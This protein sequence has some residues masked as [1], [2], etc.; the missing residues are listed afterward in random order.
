MIKLLNFSFVL[1]FCLVAV[2]ALPRL[3]AFGGA[4]LA[5][6]FILVY[7]LVTQYLFVSYR[8][9]VDLLIPTGSVFVLYSAMTAYR[10]L[11]EERHA[12]EIKSMFSHY[13]TEKVVNE[14]L[15]HPELARLGG[16][17]REVT[18]LFSDVRSFT[19]YSEHHT[20]EE[21]VSALNELLSAMTDVIMHWDGTLDK[22]V[23]DEIMAFWGAPGNQ[24]NHAEL[25]TQCSLHML[26]RLGELQHKW[27]MEGKE[28]LDIGIGLNTGEVIVGNIGSETK[29]LDY[30]I[31]GDAVNLGARVEALTRN[32]NV[33]FMMTE[34]TL[35]KI[36]HLLPVQGQK[37]VSGG[38]GHIRVTRLDEVTVKGKTK[39]VVVYEVTDSELNK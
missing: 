21:V 18:V 20:P 3:K 28:I 38:L 11:T 23:G 24:Q 9:W 6:G 30:T 8:W 16:I 36:E 22:F 13:T 33:H 29:K 12:R 4:L 35:Q 10:F 17:R 27:Q 25:A 32:Y 39:P 7:L 26:Q 1:L 19:T 15:E 37:P 2:V 14:L 5:S 31:I 34:Y